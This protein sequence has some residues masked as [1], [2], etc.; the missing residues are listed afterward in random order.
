M[1]L[2]RNP[3]GQLYLT[4]NILGEQFP[5]VF[6]P[7]LV[8]AV[9][10]LFEQGNVVLAG[11]QGTGKS[12][13]LRLLDTRTR[14]AFGQSSTDPYPIPRARFIAASVNLTSS[15]AFKL[16]ERLSRSD[17]NDP[18]EPGLRFADYLNACLIADL[19][20]SI[21]LL[22]GTQ[23]PI[24][25]LSADLSGTASGLSDF[26]AAFRRQH[27]W[28][29]S[30]GAPGTLQE[31][32]ASIDER[33]AA[34]VRLMSRSRELPAAILDTRSLP[35]EP[36]T[37]T[38][39][40]LRNAGFFSTAVSVFACIDQYEELQRLTVD[41][42]DRPPYRAFERVID[43]LLSQREGTVYYRV[44]TRPAAWQARFV[45]SEELRNYQ[46]ID[47]DDVLRP[48]E[49][50]RRGVFP[51]F[52]RDVFQRRLRWCGY[53]V[54]GRASKLVEAVFSRSPSPEERASQCVKSNPE[55][56][57]RLDPDWPASTRRVLSALARKDVVS[58]K[59]GEA[60]VRQQLSR[61]EP[62]LPKGRRLPWEEPLARWWKK[63]RKWQ[64]VLQIAVAC[65][66]RLVW[67]GEEDILALSGANILIFV[68]ISQSIFQSWIDSLSSDAQV[69][70]S[71]PLPQSIKATLQDE[72]IRTAS[73][74][75]HSKI[76]TDPGGE[77][78]QRFI[79]CAGRFLHNHLVDDRNMS[80]PGGNG[81]SLSLRDLRDAP[82]VEQALNDAQNYGFLQMRDHAPKSK[83]RGRSRKWYLHP[84]LSPF[85]EL[86]LP[87]TKEPLY[88]N[89]VDVERWL[90]DAGAL[91][92]ET[93][94]TDTQRPPT[95]APRVERQRR[96]F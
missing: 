56:A 45:R 18:D 60:W 24:P 73:R 27:P 74:A 42:P 16:A 19:L 71:S 75:W 30:V 5:V 9:A 91:P 6:S 70:L 62:V 28:G 26:L 2:P 29:P 31:L 89:I 63:E 59:L 51:A 22:L 78:R 87:H 43:D 49:H 67:Y 10:P 55:A 7:T 46:V 20:R 80:Y 21:S 94:D 96:L 88:M 47:L 65:R 92:Q 35:G 14:L 68:S 1:H 41:R 84:I 40:L 58:A 52:A 23:T 32:I 34:Y 12:M 69:S 53:P 11:T 17:R 50:S 82:A 25:S 95:E 39:T 86:T 90:I 36:L 79:D 15:N 77:A 57:I 85:Y 93:A 13:L 66:Q 44:G 81:F 33:I 76:R 72:G 8:P 38:V 54:D 48:R 61:A 4:E 83:T 37:A 64:A 3:F